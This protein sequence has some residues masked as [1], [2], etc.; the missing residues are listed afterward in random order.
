MSDRGCTQP[1]RH[2]GGGFS[3]QRG[4]FL[5]LGLVPVHVPGEFAVS[6]VS[7]FFVLFCFTDCLHVVVVLLLSLAYFVSRFRWARFFSTS[8]GE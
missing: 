7:S 1:R 8:S 6:N 3:R 4:V 2:A 5:P